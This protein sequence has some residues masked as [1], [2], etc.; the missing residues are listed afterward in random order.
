[1]TSSGDKPSA[2]S[3]EKYEYVRLSYSPDSDEQAAY[4]AYQECMVEQLEKRNAEN[5]TEADTSFAEFLAG[6]GRLD[7]GA[8][9]I[10]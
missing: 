4:M 9:N 1:M 10:N 6:C 7:G 2:I 8:E 3:E 5:P